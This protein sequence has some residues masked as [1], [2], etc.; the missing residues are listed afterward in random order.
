ASPDA[1]RLAGRLQDVAGAAEA[2][3]DR[4][5]ARAAPATVVGDV[6]RSVLP[7][8]TRVLVLRDPT[9]PLVSIEALWPGGLRDE[10]ARSNG[11]SALIGGLLGRGT[12]TRSAGQVDDEV[13]GMAGTLG[14]FAGR[15]GLG[16]RAELLASRWERGLELVADCLRNPSFADDDI[17]RARPVLLD[18]IR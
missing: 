7:S 9:V 12:K 2:R 17:E 10:D 8:G 6:V 4:R 13:E 18:E 14:G 1:G 5:A 11:A 3:A 16:L 15:N